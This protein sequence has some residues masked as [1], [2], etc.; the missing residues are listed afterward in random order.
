MTSTSSSNCRRLPSQTICVRARCSRTPYESAAA[1][2]PPPEKVSTT[3]RLLE[4]LPREGLTK[5]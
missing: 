5:R 2:V 4:L 1:R 3:S